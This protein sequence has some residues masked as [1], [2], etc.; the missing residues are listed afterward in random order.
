MP[1][2]SSFTTHEWADS[3]EKI[4]R[5]GVRIA[6]E[7]ATGE[8]V[9]VAGSIGP[10]GALVKPYG[11][12]TLWQVRG[13]LRGAGPGLLEAGVDL[14]LLETFGSLLEAAEAVRA[15]RSL[16]SEI[17]I[18]A[19]MTFLSDGRTAFGESASHALATLA[20]AGADVGRDELHA[21]AA[22]DPRPVRA[23][24]RRHLRAALGDAER[25][26]PE[27]RARPQRVPLS[28]DYLLEYAPAFVEAGR[29]DRRRVLRHDSRAHPARWRARCRATGA[30]RRR[31]PSPSSS[32]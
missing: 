5:E 30:R 23:T 11:T 29:R 17:P 24:A 25:G 28:P 31:R 9:F 18:V 14:I 19:G 7:A 13:D 32:R 26:I 10:L 2:E 20:L 3:L 6:R 21:R 27:P 4:N 22:G 12:L 8:L 1:T 16:S 15:A